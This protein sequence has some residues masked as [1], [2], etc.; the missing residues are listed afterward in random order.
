MKPILNTSPSDLPTLNWMTIAYKSLV[1]SES[2][3]HEFAYV[4][5]YVF[6]FA[7]AVHAHT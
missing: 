2:D 3:I 6:V 7:E 4:S 1:A 5:Q